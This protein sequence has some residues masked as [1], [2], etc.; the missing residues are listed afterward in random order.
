FVGMAGN[1]S[2]EVNNAA[3][4][5]QIQDLVKQGYLVRTRSDANT[6]EAR[7]NDTARR[8]VAFQS[9]AQIISTDYPSFE[10]A[11]WHNFTVAFPG[12]V[13]ARCNPVTAP[14]TCTAADV[15]E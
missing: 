4:L 5:H 1:G 8:D 7:Q 10:P 2:A 14:A 15:A 12:G 6:V 11:P 3:A 9:G 13:I